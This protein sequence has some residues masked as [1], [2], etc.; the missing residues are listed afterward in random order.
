MIQ[1]LSP[2][3]SLYLFASTYKSPSLLIALSTHRRYS[4]SYGPYTFSSKIK[5]HLYYTPAA[6]KLT[7]IRSVDMNIRKIINSLVKNHHCRAVRVLLPKRSNRRSYFIVGILWDYER[8]ESSGKR[9]EELSVVECWSCSGAMEKK[10]GFSDTL[11][12]IQPM[13]YLG[14]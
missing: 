7:S 4:R 6:F 11:R 5:T 9:G 8:Q 3:C 14:K 2:L 1:M 12:E 13:I 10:E